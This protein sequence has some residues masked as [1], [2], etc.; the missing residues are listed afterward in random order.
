MTLPYS[1][2]NP[3]NKPRL[4]SSLPND[5]LLDTFR[6]FPRHEINSWKWS[7]INTLQGF[8]LVSR[9]WK[10]IINNNRSTLPRLFAYGLE[11][12]IVRNRRRGGLIVYL[13]I[14]FQ[15]HDEYSRHQ[16]P[17]IYNWSKREECDCALGKE[18]ETEV[19]L[20][21]YPLLILIPLPS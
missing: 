17:G 2:N 16:Q 14:H 19:S 15:G 7:S 21:I 5:I 9:Q 11:I 8:Q 3:K 10:A 20:S 13:F 4:L 18:E 1:D 6:L 12:F